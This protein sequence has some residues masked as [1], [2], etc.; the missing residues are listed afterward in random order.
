[1]NR[2]GL[3]SFKTA[4]GVGEHISLFSFFFCPKVQRVEGERKWLQKSI[5][6]TETCSSGL[7]LEFIK[8][9]G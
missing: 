4:I 1:M 8:E 5:Y 6:Q 3:K 7:K 2:E 9:M